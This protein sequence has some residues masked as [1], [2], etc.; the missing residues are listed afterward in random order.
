VLGDPLHPY[1]AGLRGAVPVPDPTVAQPL[2]ATVVGEVPDP[3]APPSGC[4]FHP[5]CPLAEDVCRTEL[6]LPA[7]I[8]PGHSAACHVAARTGA[9]T[10]RDRRVGGAAETRR[11]GVHR[12]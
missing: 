8:R 4:P 6:P 11:S 7:E 3:V 10:R 2:T 1:T 12:S 5:R 9:S